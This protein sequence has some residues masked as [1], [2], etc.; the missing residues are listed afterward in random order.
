VLATPWENIAAN[1][2]VFTTH[3]VLTTRQHTAA[4]HRP[5]ARKQRQWRDGAASTSSCVV[6]YTNV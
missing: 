2:T 1:A 6:F 5:R 3:H 4:S